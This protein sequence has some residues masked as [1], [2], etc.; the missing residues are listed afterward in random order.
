MEVLASVQYSKD[1]LVAR[2]RRAVE[3]ALR[4]KRISMAESGRFMRRY[5][6]RSRATP[7]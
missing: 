6:S 1:D 2:V 3:A 4:D 7:T 5:E